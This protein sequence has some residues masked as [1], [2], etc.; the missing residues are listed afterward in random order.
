MKHSHPAGKRYI[1]ERR[2]QQNSLYGYIIKC[3][4]D[5]PA[6]S[7]L[8]IGNRVLVKGSVAS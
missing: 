8:S 6:S 3:E 7:T 5:T 4:C 2:Y 1:I